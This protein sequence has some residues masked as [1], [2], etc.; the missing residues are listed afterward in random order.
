MK[1]RYASIVVAC[2]IAVSTVAVTASGQERRR[3][4]RI[5]PPAELGTLE[6]PDRELYQKPDQIMDALGI[7]DGSI[8]AEVGAGGG[9]FTVRLARRVGPRG[10][11]YAEDIQEEMVEAIERRMQRESLGNVRTVLGKNDDSRLPDDALDAVLI[12]DAY[13]EFEKPI[14]ML[15]SVK[16]ALKPTGRVA[17]VD[18][19]KDGEGPG[20]P[21]DDR[22]EESVVIAKAEAAGL[23]LVSRETFLPYQ[24]MLVFARREAP[25]ESTVQT[26]R[27]TPNANA[28]RGNSRVPPATTPPAPPAPAKPPESARPPG[29][30][31]PPGRF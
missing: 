30:P 25:I 11:I 26:K 3:P 23:R 19:R 6:G 21:L 28:T 29:V 12:V 5:F 17:I 22:V 9:W 31:P 1:T 13:Y 15:R 16:D 20:P 14:D 24:Y 10:L 2:L 18:Y 4:V 27:P 8:V 7:A